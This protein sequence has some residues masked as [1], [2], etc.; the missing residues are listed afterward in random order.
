MPWNQ[1]QSADLSDE[2]LQAF[3]RAGVSWLRTDFV[4]KD[5]EAKEGN[6]ILKNMISGLNGKKT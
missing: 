2:P 4:W 6:T 1:F 3:E 5:I